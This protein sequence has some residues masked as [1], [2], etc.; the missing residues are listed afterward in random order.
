MGI[1]KYSKPQGS[2]PAAP[3][4]PAKAVAEAVEKGLEKDVAA[5]EDGTEKALTYEEILKEEGID[6]SEA[7]AI[8]DALLVD[9][10]YAEDVKITDNTTVR[11]RTRNYADYVRWTKAMETERPAYVDE[12]SEI[13]LRYFL[14]A[15]LERYRDEAFDFPTGSPKD[16]ETA[17][18]ARHERVLKFPEPVVE[19]LGRKLN[20]FD[21]K[22]R[23]CLND[24]AVESF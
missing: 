9:G 18:K 12:K 5:T 16:E 2:L 1:G 4:T 8:R 7:R 13:T 22:V 15:S 17:F 23:I 11:F 10:Y 6:I 14:A 19:L 20:R 24:G 21:T 3:P